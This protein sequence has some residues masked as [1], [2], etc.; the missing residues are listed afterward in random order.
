MSSNEGKEEEFVEVTLKLSVLTGPF[1][2]QTNCT[3]SCILAKGWS[4][5]R[6]ILMTETLLRTCLQFYTA[7]CNVFIADQLVRQRL[8]V[9][10]A[11]ETEWR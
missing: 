11:I 10:K 3:I 7:L 9:R 5:P 8:V 2:D 1:N 4:C 6:I